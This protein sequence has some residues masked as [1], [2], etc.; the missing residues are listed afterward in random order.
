M[1]SQLINLR[2]EAT[3]HFT[4]WFNSVHIKILIYLFVFVFVKNIKLKEKI[5]NGSCNK[6]RI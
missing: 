1:V 6:P 3:P 5:E 2:S 4:E